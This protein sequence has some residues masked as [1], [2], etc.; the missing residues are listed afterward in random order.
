MNFESRIETFREAF[1]VAPVRK[2]GKWP[3]LQPIHFDLNALEK[4]LERWKNIEEDALP[5]LLG[6]TVSPNIEGRPILNIFFETDPACLIAR[7][8][9]EIPADGSVPDFSQVWPYSSWWQ[10]ELSVFSRIRFA[11][12]DP[13][14]GIR[15]RL[16]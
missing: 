9:S 5:R 15:W 16:A 13:Q 4:V 6:L 11:G 7:L 8:E 12:H 3:T 14:E 10:E 1:G 2:I